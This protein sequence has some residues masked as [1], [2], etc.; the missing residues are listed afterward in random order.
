MLL[1]EGIL[2]ILMLA[3]LSKYDYKL[4]SRSI[5]SNVKLVLFLILLNLLE[6]HWLIKL[7][8]L[9]VHN[10]IIHLLCC[11]LVT[12]NQVSFHHHLSPFTL[13]YLPPPFFPLVN[14]IFLSV[15]MRVF[16]FVGF[17]LITVAL[18]WAWLVHQFHLSC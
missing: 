4:H 2:D 7:Y 18:L 11:V 13:F 8:R 3:T 17:Y 10:S 6:W 1:L 5:G 14:T 15:S 16:L 12:P 9:Q